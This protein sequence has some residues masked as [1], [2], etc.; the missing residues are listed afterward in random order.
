MSIISGGGAVVGAGGAAAGGYQISRSLR[1]NSADTAYLSRTGGTST[2]RKIHTFSF[3]TKYSVKGGARVVASAGS[4]DNNREWLGIDSN[5][6]AYQVKDSSNFYDVVSTQVFRDPSAWYHFVVAVD[7]TQATSSNRVKIYVNDS[8]ITAFDTANYP[9]QNDDLF[10]NDSVGGTSYIGALRGFVSSTY[11]YDGY[12]TEFNFID[13][14]ALTPSDF[15]ETNPTTGVW[16]PKAYTGSYGT[17]GFYLNF[18]DNSST[19][20][21]GEDQAGSNDWTLNNFSVTAGAGNDSLV[22]TPTNYGTDTG[23]GGEVRGNYATLNPL[24]L[25][26]IVGTF[27]NGNLQVT[28]A[29]AYPEALSTINVNGGK[30]YAEATIT[31]QV[32][33]YI[34]L[35]VVQNPS[36]TASPI[37]PLRHSPCVGYRTDGQKNIDL[38]Y[39]A[40]GASFT[41]NDV[42]GIAVDVPGNSITFY[43]SGVSQGAISYTFSSKD[44]FFACGGTGT[45]G[46]GNDT[47]VFN[48]GQRPFSYAA[49]SNFKSLCTQNL[50]EPTIVDGGEYFNTVLYT[51]NGSTQ[52]ITGVGFQ[53]DWVWIKERN[54]TSDHCSF[55]A[56]RGAT[57]RLRQNQTAAEDT[58]ANSLTAFNSDG[59]SL[60]SDASVNESAS[61]TYVAWNWKANGAGSSNTDGTITS[62]VSVNT[63]SGFSIITYT[64][65]GANAT[66][67]H[68]LGVAPSMV[69]V[70]SRSVA[71]RGWAVWHSSLAATEALELSS[72][73]AKI[74]SAAS[75]NSTAPTSTV[76]SLGTRL[77]TNESGTTFV[78]YTF[79]AIPGY[80]AFGSYTGNGSADGPFVYTGFRPAF[81]LVKVSTA[82]RSWVISDGVRNPYNV[83]N[84][85]LVPSSSSA[86]GTN[87]LFDFTSNGFKV[88]DSLVGINESSETL[89]YAAFAE[90]PFKYSL[91]R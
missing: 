75:W 4:D 89:I 12:I 21:L 61:F 52:S 9:P 46:L 78:C 74:T 1:F 35:G 24:A 8:Q 67:G 29:N 59:F 10:F 25:T 45:A 20:T 14:Q 91:A 65:T 56:V 80:S 72:T 33:E 50:P 43:K 71:A 38:T 77:A 60:G 84:L 13:G 83:T 79:A 3:W 17:N 64:G 90:N 69:I 76:I 22:D 32:A 39:S 18:S 57:E 31:S 6:F 47:V 41:V 55:D 87:N 16:Q 11:A 54:S 63:T 85:Y 51:G 5:K 27:S 15:G 26:N 19:T 62:T 23:L 7:T 34:I 30:F 82:I 81:V 28:R 37:A 42:I 73:E 48:F 49:P 40:Y 44:Q 88:R 66:V 58:V 86:E 70:K 36:D 2:N 53:P 68:G